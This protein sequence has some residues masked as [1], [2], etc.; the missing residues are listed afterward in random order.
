[1]ENKMK[2]AA[3]GAAAVGG[4]GA[5]AAAYV[6]GVRPWHLRWGATDD[7]LTAWL[8]GDDVKPDADIQV[9]HAI[10]IA[11]PPESVWRWLIQIGQDRGGFYSYDWL[12]S[13]VGLDIHNTDEIRYEWQDLKLGDFIRGAPEGWMG[14]RFDDTAGWHVIGIEPYRYLILRD[15]IEHGSWSFVL[16]QLNDGSTRLI[17]RARGDRGDSFMEK[18]Y[19][20]GFFEPAHFL[21]ERKMM[22]T[23]K[24]RAEDNVALLH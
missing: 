21:M 10:T 9:T 22:L 12:E 14:G 5:L 23:I 11:A 8:P 7:E 4:I 16:K 1:M 18:L 3:I 19:S 2:K 24:E 15:E 20:Y 17:V 13:L 6:F